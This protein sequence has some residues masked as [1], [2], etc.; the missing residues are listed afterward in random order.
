[1]KIRK[2]G[3]WLLG[4]VVVLILIVGSILLFSNEKKDR[5]NLLSVGKQKEVL[6]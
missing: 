4:A 5:V 3:V 2:S 6:R 1:M